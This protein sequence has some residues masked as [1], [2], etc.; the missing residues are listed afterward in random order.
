MRNGKVRMAVPVAVF[1][2][3]F[4]QSDFAVYLLVM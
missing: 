3:A 1:S 2:A 4:F